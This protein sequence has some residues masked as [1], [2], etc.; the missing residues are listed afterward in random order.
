[1]CL[2]K[3][4]RLSALLLV[5]VDDV[6]VAASDLHKIRETEE[7]LAFYYELKEFGEVQEFLGISI[8]RKNQVFLHQKGFTKRILERFGYSDL[9]AAATPWN[10]HFQLPIEWEKL[11]EGSEL[12]SQQTGSTNYLSC[13]MR[14]DITF[15][16]RQ[17]ARLQRTRKRCIRNLR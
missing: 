6:L 4:D 16:S 8:V 7:I 14:P 11:P 17:P 9:S 12:Y 2:F 5:Y 10:A 15:T 3:N 1:M 13:H